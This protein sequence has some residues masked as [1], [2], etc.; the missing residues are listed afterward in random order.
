MNAAPMQSMARALGV[1]ACLWLLLIAP[2][3]ADN[4]PPHYRGNSIDCF[5][6]HMPHHAPGLTITAVEGN[7]NLC[8]TCHNPGGLA[9]AKPFVDGD[10]ALPG[11]SGTTH[12]FDSGPSG[13]VE[14]ALTNTSNGNVRSGG[15]FSG[16]IERSYTITITTGGDVGTA[17]FNWNDSEGASG[18]ATSGPAVA[19]NDGLDVTFLAG[20]TS[21][22]FV[23]AD[24]WTLFVR[25]DLGLPDLASSDIEERRMARRVTEGKVV[26]SVC[27]DQHRQ[28]LQPFDPAAPPFSGPGTGEGRHYQRRS[29]DINQMCV[30]CHA[31]RDV[32]SSTQGSHPVGVGIPGG[33]FQTPP[34]LP[35]DAQAE[36]R[37]LSCHSPHFT[38]SGGANGGQ[39][40][41]YLLRTSINDLC[42]ECHTLAD[43]AA[44]S[45]FDSVD[46]LLWPGGQY[47]SSFPAHSA[48]KRGACVNCHWPH[49]WP[50]DADLPQDYSR[51]WVERYDVAADG[52]DPADAEDLCFTCHDGTPA[53]TD[54][55]GEFQ[56]GSNGA[57]IFHHPVSD[58]EQTAGRSVECVNCHNPHQA[59][60]DNKLAGVT[61]VDLAGNPV[62]PATGNNRD[63]VQHELCFKCHGDTFNSSRPETTN[64]RLDFQTSNSAFHPVA[65]P[66][67]NQSTNLANALLGGLATTSTIECTDCHNNQATADALGPA[68]NSAASPKGPHGSS[69]AAI[70]RAAYRATYLESEGP[71]D[72]NR[73]DFELCFLC[74]DPARLV[75][76]RRSDDNPPASTN[77]YDDIGGEDNL[78]HLHLED[79]INKT[80]AT[81]KNCHFNIHSNR[82]ANNTQYRVDGVVFGSPPVGF[83]TH[84]V[85]FSPDITPLGARAKPEWWI[86]TNTLERRCFLN[87]HDGEMDGND[88]AQYRP[89]GG[90]DSPT[91]P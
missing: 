58:P 88:G 74:H 60:P 41:G 80:R 5:N 37:C 29:N 52:S 19:L 45:H 17:T 15:A 24:S 11:V 10:Q 9:A 73:A 56:K 36:L 83:K 28:D 2:A 91:L 50:D 3:T 85:N 67:H 6:C 51:L 65:G 44:G 34:S 75:E 33:D 87:C 81:C 70:R 26:C 77:F 78:H 79:R 64:K 76:A 59:R 90:D 18:S 66:G 42:F 71:T 55:R 16:R 84:L 63:L 46:G 49:G 4:D 38:D 30:T 40:D 32:V 43:R 68:A 22:D 14:A 57:E 62:G 31:A 35:L 82:T 61:G 48:D 54:I 1:L 47:G 39:G 23:L 25:T 86:N 21:P 12:R 53:A 8:M 13:H 7:P 20:D 69:N 89:P 27:H 72:Y